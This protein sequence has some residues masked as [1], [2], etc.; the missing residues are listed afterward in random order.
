MEHQAELVMAGFSIFYQEDWVKVLVPQFIIC[1]TL[2]ISNQYIQPCMIKRLNIFRTAIYFCATHACACAILYN[3]TENNGLLTWLTLI[4]GW[5][6]I[7]SIII[8]IHKRKMKEFKLNKVAPLNTIKIMGNKQEI[9]NG[10]NNVD[11]TK[12]KN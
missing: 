7:W 10:G 4:L 3:V 6:L 11:K 12:H 2:S 1:L 9:T 8:C 5:I